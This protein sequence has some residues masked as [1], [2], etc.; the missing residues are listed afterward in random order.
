VLEQLWAPIVA[1]TAAYD[2]RENGLISSTVVTASLLPESPL[3]VVQLSK[4]NL[5]HDLACASGALAVHFLPDDERGL[6]LFQTLG[7]RTGR[8]TSKLDDIAT[9]PGRTGA[10]ILQDAVAYV[11]AR[12][13]T[14]HE[15][16]GSTIVVA[17]VVGGARLRDAAVLTID[18]VRERLPPEWAEEWERRLEAELAAA[19]QHR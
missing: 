19:R 5:T 2:G 11:E 9:A 13:A 1:V 16:E 17:D 4:T 15:V 14:T 3:I 10:P 6:E 18:G 8:Q 12:V 7:I